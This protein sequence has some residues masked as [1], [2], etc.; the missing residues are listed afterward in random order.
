RVEVG[1]LASGQWVAIFG[2]GYNSAE[3]DGS[4]ST[5]GTAKLFVVDIATGRLI[6]TIDTGAA[7]TSYANGLSQPLAVDINSDFII[8]YVYA[9][10]LEGDLWK[11]DLTNSSAA[12]WSVGRLF[13]GS[14]NQPVF[15]RP[16]I[17]TH[18]Q[19]GWML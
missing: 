16:T 13:N 8:D 5:N 17:M 3:A 1:K 4:A 10:D 19:G 11:F 12:A 2:N 14:P 15:V 9:G 6:R 18:P 7:G